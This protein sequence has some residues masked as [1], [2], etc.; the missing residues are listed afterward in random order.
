MTQAVEMSEAKDLVVVEQPPVEEQPAPPPRPMPRPP[1]P[2]FIEQMM[3]YVELRPWTTALVIFAALTFVHVTLLNLAGVADGLYVGDNFVLTSPPNSITIVL[4]AFIAYS[5]VLPT[6]LSHACIRAYD[7]LRPSLMLDDRGY[8]E[9]RAGIVDPF[10][11]SRFGF[12]A[13]FVIVLTPGVGEIWRTKLQGD[14]TGFALQAIWL[15][16]RLAVIFALIGSTL[17]YIVRLQR[18]FR[19][20]TAEHLRI[21]LFDFAPLRPVSRYAK[22]LAFYL[23]VLLALLGPPIVEPDAL[24]QGAVVFAAGILF[25]AAAVIASMAGTARSIAAA[26]K[27]AIAELS[28]YSRELWRRAYAGQRIVEAMAIPAL[29]AMITTRAEI[30]RQTEWPG[31][32]SVA[33]RFALAALIP[34]ATWFGATLMTSLTALLSP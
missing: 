9:T 34:L 15:Y 14:G 6:L 10:V 30:R 25:I 2:G 32:W 1:E 19:S 4:L 27:A 24:I 22:L 29:G 3:L 23:L 18:A 21:D 20:V 26:K 13:L 7:T 11:T 8:G 12:A 17:A 28:T 31:K 5:A 33:G 16:L